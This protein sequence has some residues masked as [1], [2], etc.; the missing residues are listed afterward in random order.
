MR[1]H[2]FA[3]AMLIS[4][5]FILIEADELSHKIKKY[6][7]DLTVLSPVK[8]AGSVDRHPIALAGLYK[9]DLRMNHI[10]TPG[11]YDFTG[12]DPEIVAIIDNPD[13]SAGRVALAMN[14]FDDAKIVPEESLVKIAYSLIESSVLPPSWVS[15]INEKF[16]L[17]VVADEYY[18]DVYINSGVTKPVFVQPHGIY[19]DDFLEEEV[20]T[21][22]GEPFVFGC[23]GVFWPRKNQSLLVK[24]FIKEFGNDP[25]VKLVL[26]ARPFGGGQKYY[27]KVK[28][29]IKKSH[30]QNI[31]IIHEALSKDDYKKFFKSLDCYV[32]LSKGEGFSI[33]PREALALGK[34]TI[35]SNNTAH[36]T[37]CDTGYVY[38]V[39][40][41]IAHPVPPRGYEFDCDID[42]ACKA[43]REVY[44]NYE[45]YL[46]KAREGREWVK[47]YL[48]QNLKARFMN[49]FKPKIVLFG[50]KNIITDDYIMTNSLALYEKYTA[51]VNETKD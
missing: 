36:K 15:F 44:N 33:T 30:C 49:F 29:I 25:R 11:F 18:R 51:L 32:I 17:A 47:S 19:V 37:I 26:H 45:L 23:S 38:G 50:E 8:F 13:K 41:D 20:R 35:I 2:I 28:K 24:A 39:R 4:Y 12:V 1:K 6:K 7:Y 42:D 16:D 27:E 9:N 48:W 21:R 31:E 14:G 5:S 22:P 3:I 10:A 34:P 46:A 43:L 40:S